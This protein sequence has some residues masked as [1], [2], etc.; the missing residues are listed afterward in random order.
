M[1]QRAVPDLLYTMEVW[2]LNKK[3]LS[4]QW[5]D[6]DEIQ[7]ISFRPGEWEAKLPIF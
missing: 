1:K 7:L 6:D 2:Y 5:G 3:I 4:V